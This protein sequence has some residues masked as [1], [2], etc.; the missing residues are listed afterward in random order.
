V[1]NPKNEGLADVGFREFALFVPLIILA[2]WI[3]LYPAPF[4]HRLDTSVS[5]VIARVSPQY[6]QGQVAAD[7]LPA[8]PEEPK[9]PEAVAAAQFTTPPCED[10]T[11]PPKP[12]A[13]H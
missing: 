10:T 2:V 5:R 8:K 9:T 4:L 7:C 3:G 1:E 13:A 11:S 6:V 12:G